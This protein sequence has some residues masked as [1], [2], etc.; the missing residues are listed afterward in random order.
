MCGI[1]G[2]QDSGSP[3]NSLMP[4]VFMQKMYEILDIEFLK[5]QIWTQDPSW[6]KFVSNSFLVDVRRSPA[7]A[8]GAGKHL[9]IFEFSWG[10]WALRVTEGAS[11]NPLSAAMR[12]LRFFF[13]VE[14]LENVYFKYFK[15]WKRKIVHN[16]LCEALSETK[17]RRTGPETVQN[18]RT[19]DLRRKE[20]LGSNQDFKIYKTT[21]FSKSWWKDENKSNI[22]ATSWLTTWGSKPPKRQGKRREN[23]FPKFSIFKIQNDRNFKIW[24]FG[25]FKSKGAEK[26]FETMENLHLLVGAFFCLELKSVVTHE[27]HLSP[28]EYHGF[29]GYVLP[30]VDDNRYVL[31]VLQ[32]P[33]LRGLHGCAKYG[34]SKGRLINP[35]DSGRRSLTPRL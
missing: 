23:A 24:K 34:R 14:I 26:T 21:K 4:S 28:K 13:C 11:R 12:S 32:N 17:Q 25:G 3:K 29:G 1:C 27:P 7:F 22:W 5:I 19:A 10:K 30:Y 31:S 8:R 18:R 20:A 2:D 6:H 33:N 9:T 15:V 35:L 16:W